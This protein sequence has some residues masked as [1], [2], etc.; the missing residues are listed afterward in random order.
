M[1]T[2]GKIRERQEIQQFKTNEKTQ[3]YKEQLKFKINEYINE[4]HHFI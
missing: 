1:K 2:G 3:I 4:I